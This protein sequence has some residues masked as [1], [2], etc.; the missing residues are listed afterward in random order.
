M[1]PS[2]ENHGRKRNK[3][4]RNPV[5]KHHQPHNPKPPLPLPTLQPSAP[6]A[7]DGA[8]VQGE[9]GEESEDRRRVSGEVQTALPNL[10]CKGCNRRC[11]DHHVVALLCFVCV[12]ALFPP[13]VLFPFAER[14]GWEVPRRERERKRGRRIDVLNGRGS[15]PRW[16][17]W[18]SRSPSGIRKKQFASEF[19]KRAPAF[20]SSTIALRRTLFH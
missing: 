14:F 8:S 1:T 3:A 20:S 10:R 12:C 16:L 9:G 18:I 6:Q 17:S 19:A 13:F 4:F 2:R 5:Y 15:T 11:E 7:H